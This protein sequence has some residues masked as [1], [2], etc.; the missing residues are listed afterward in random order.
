MRKKRISAVVSSFLLTASLMSQAFPLEAM[1]EEFQSE[2]TTLTVADEPVTILGNTPEV[3]T[4]SEGSVSDACG[5]TTTWTYDI[6]TKTLYLQGEG[7]VEDFCWNSETWLDY[8]PEA[9]NLVIESSITAITAATLSECKNLKSVIIPRLSLSSEGDVS[10]VSLNEWFGG[11]DMRKQLVSVTI[12]EATEIPKEYFK[13]MNLLES[14]TLPDTVETIGESAFSGC[15]ALQAV[16]VSAGLKTIASSA[17]KNCS[18]LTEI[19]L[20]E[21]AETI[22]EKAFDGCTGVLALNLPDSLKT[23]ESYAFNGMS[24]LKELVIPPNVENLGISL[25]GAANS[26]GAITLPFALDPKDTQGEGYV[27]QLDSYILSHGETMPLKK[28]TITGGTTIPNSFMNGHSDVTEVNLPDSITLICKNAFYNCSGLTEIHLPAN[29]EIIREG[30][31]RGC[32]G[33]TE[34]TLPENIKRIESTAFYGM[35]EVTELTIP[36]SAE[37]IGTDLFGNDSKMQKITLPFAGESRDATLENGCNLVSTI[38]YSS[39]NREMPL[40]EITFTGGTIVP[41]G[42]FHYFENL[43]TVNF[44][45]T[46]TEL[47]NNLFY[48][49]GAYYG[50]QNAA[51]ESIIL[52]DSIISIGN[53]TFRNCP[54][55]ANIT[56]SENLREIGERAFTDTAWL[57]AQTAKGFINAGNVVIGYNGDYKE[58]LTIPEGTIGIGAKA[59][60]SGTFSTV[61][62]PDGLLYI[63]RVAF[64]SCRNLKEVNIPDSVEEIDDYAFY[65]CSSLE[66]VTIPA[67]VGTIGTDVFSESSWSNLQEDGPIYIGTKFYG[68]KGTMPAHTTLTLRDGTDTIVDDALSGYANLDEIILPDSLKTIGKNAFKGCISLTEIS[69]PDSVTD[70]GDNAFNGCTELT[71]VQLSAN[72]NKIGSYAFKECAKLEKADIP[73][74]TKSIGGSAFYNCGALRE[75]ILPD[76]LETVESYV[77]GFSNDFIK[78]D[79]F[80]RTLTIAEGSEKVT[81]TMTKE[82]SFCTNK[83]NLPEGITTICES[84][85]EKYTLVDEIILPSTVTTA[86]KR[87]FYNLE[88]LKTIGNQAV[89]SEIGEEAFRNTSIEETPAMTPDCVLNKLSFGYCKSLKKALLPENI[90][91]IPRELFSNC[92]AIPEIVIP[93]SVTQIDYYAFGNNISLK[94]ITVPNQI[95]DE[96]AMSGVIVTKDTINSAFLYDKSLLDGQ[97]LERTIIFAEGRKTLSSALM[98]NFRNEAVSVV[99]P[100]SLEKIEGETFASCPVLTSLTIPDNVTEIGTSLCWNSKA[101]KEVKLSKNLTIIPQDTF[102]GCEALETVEIPDGVTEIGN[103]AF[104]NCHSLKTMVLPDS[105]TTVGAEVFAECISLKSLKLSENLTE[106][107]RSFCHSCVKLKSI[108]IPDSVTEIGWYAFYDCISLTK[109]EV[110]DNITDAPLAFGF[111]Y[112][113]M[114]Y[115]DVTV[116]EGSQTVPKAIVDALKSTMRTLTLPEGVTYLS[117]YALDGCKVLQSVTLPDSLKTIGVGAFRNTGIS[118]LI[119]PDGVTTLSKSVC[120]KCSN[121]R[122]VKFSEAVSIIPDLTFADC[123]NLSKVDTVRTAYS[124]RHNSSFK[125]C[126]SLYDSRFSVLNRNSIDF[127]ASKTEVQP[128]GFVNLS[129]HYSFNEGVAD[130]N[131][132]KVK[133]VLPKGVTAVEASLNDGEYNASSNIITLNNTGNNVTRT[134]TVKFA[135][136]AESYRLS[137]VLSATIEGESI[138]ETIGVLDISALELSIKAPETV[139]HLNDIK[140]SGVSTP[141]STVT[142]YADGE[143]VGT[144]EANKSNGRYYTLISL[145]SKD[146]TTYSLTAKSGDSETEAVTLTYTSGVPEIEQVTIGYWA[147]GKWS[148]YYMMHYKDLTECFTSGKDSPVM[149]FNQAYPLQFDIV[150]DNPYN[151]QMVFVTSTKGDE[152]YSMRANWIPEEGVYRAEGYFNP[153]NTSYI[154]GT[155]GIEMVTTPNIVYDVTENILYGDETSQEIYQ[156]NMDANDEITE[157]AKEMYDDSQEIEI[158]THED[159]TID[160]IHIGDSAEALYQLFYNNSTDYFYRGTEKIYLEEVIKNPGNYGFVRSTYRE[161]DSETNTLYEFYDRILNSEELL[162]MY[163]DY[164]YTNHLEEQIT[165]SDIAAMMYGSGNISFKLAI[166]LDDS[167]EEAADKTPLNKL[168]FPNYGTIVAKADSSGGEVGSKTSWTTNSWNYLKNAFSWNNVKEKASEA[169]GYSSPSNE[170]YKETQKLM[171]MMDVKLTSAEV[172]GAGAMLSVVGENSNVKSLFEDTKQNE[173]TISV[174]LRINS[175]YENVEKVWNSP[176]MNVVKNTYDI[177]KGLPSP[178]EFYEQANTF[179]SR[180]ADTSENELNTKALIEAYKK[181]SYFDPTLHQNAGNG[182]AAHDLAGLRT[183]NAIYSFLTASGLSIKSL[184]DLVGKTGGSAWKVNALA[185]LNVLIWGYN[186]DRLW[187]LADEYDYWERNQKYYE[188]IVNSKYS[189]ETKKKFAIIDMLNEAKIDDPYLYH[190]LYEKYVREAGITPNFIY[191]PSGYVYEAVETNPLTGAT[192]TVYYQDPETGEEI[193]W[194]ATDYDQMNPLITDEFGAYAWD[195]PEGLWRVKF[196]LEGYETMY[197]DWMDVPP[198][199]TEVNFNAVS[200]AEPQLLSTIEAE[201]KII[202]VFT[203]YMDNSTLTPETVKILSDGKETAVKITPAS[204]SDSYANTYVIEPE[205]GTFPAGTLTVSLSENCKSYS[206]VA[207]KAVTADAERPDTIISLTIDGEQIA[208]AGTETEITLH[209]MPASVAYGKKVTFSD[210]SGITAMKE[211]AVFDENGTAVIQLEANRTGTA[212]LTFGIE[213]TDLTADYALAVISSDIYEIYEEN[214]PEETQEEPVMYGDANGDNIVNL[215]DAVLIRRY[216]AGGW[217]A[218]IDEKAADVNHDGVINLKDVVLIRRYIVG[219]WDVEF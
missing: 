163:L 4:P 18:T 147:H 27:T 11:Q 125:N 98:N 117:D 85:F 76:T 168:F 49:T 194:N 55:L 75:V 170:R 91:T 184:A 22:G 53:D 95:E 15:T 188:S 135:D 142:I 86:E 77:F 166:S 175:L 26:L 169:W 111:E 137:A 84:A 3:P 179:T 43:K 104:S 6:E 79:D 139:N 132:S 80:A 78:E 133:I 212:S 109:I 108:S 93:D 178:V 187:A 23:V 216:I 143:K 13:D 45:D 145:P 202:L 50:F 33:I 71:Q 127:S 207:V 136:S 56:F 206:G 164:I 183:I 70:I 35:N 157:I 146:E 73:Y 106:I 19:T 72:L 37:Y 180:I 218:E 171:N 90:E 51:L 59:F 158:L 214:L 177:A 114:I 129:V 200:L 112:D 52:P 32:T 54:N 44:A 148:S 88:N 113:D 210:A 134:F 121:L 213:D 10:S 81:Y 124:F 100:K 209:A 7:E 204:G 153:N 66:T 161:Y 102:R 99:L 94:T 173:P 65:R 208:S 197:S 30:A 152:T 67:T 1:A 167:T 174:D 69:I 198:I 12:L 101:L 105:V 87:A 159:M 131:T 144:A 205:T 14:V 151:A 116:R 138:E 89:F 16:P 46:M 185:G 38:G 165:D 190:S 130:K 193:E 25:I 128:N 189:D 68:Y 119:I 42:Y 181:S 191:D 120:E 160:R 215:K 8:A 2:E 199:R 196:E 5:E 60:Q 34:L 115:R 58:S 48:A 126:I 41:N 97:T 154:P 61:T 57:N 92:Y 47:G 203:K 17:F 24:E 40:T 186:I 62:L 141:G 64:D 107:G 217:E 155:L 74:G 118:E 195:V 156:D 63:G 150:L 36:D 192:M 96:E 219:G 21:G 39:S 20:P 82:L 172:A 9:E 140:I 103:N 149:T 122:Y 162:L 110:S 201:G 182:G 176:E 31:F 28:V 211:Q 123:D 29:L 83:V